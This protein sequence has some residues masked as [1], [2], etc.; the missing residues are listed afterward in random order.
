MKSQYKQLPLFLLIL[1]F[2]IPLCAQESTPDTLIGKIH[3]QVEGFKNEDGTVKIAL[4]NSK[5]SYQSNEEIF[6]GAK[7]KITG[8]KVSYTFENVPYGEYALKIFHDE[9]NNDKF[10]TNFFGVP[11]EPYGF[12]NNV[13]GKFG[14]PSYDDAKFEL[15]EKEINLSVEV[16]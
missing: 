15:K 6:M 5:E 4:V 16:K 13:R 9:N 3:V 7:E 12:S 10:D 14:P 2:I 1:L 11:K 8:K